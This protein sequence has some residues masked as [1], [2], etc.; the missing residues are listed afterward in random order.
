[1]KPN[2]EHRSTDRPA[3]ETGEGYSP[4]SVTFLGTLADLTREKEV[5]AADGT[6]VLGLDVGS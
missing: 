2:D 3:G 1:M 5:G 6:Q 4:P